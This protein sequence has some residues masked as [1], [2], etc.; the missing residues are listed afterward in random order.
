MAL[1]CLRQQVSEKQLDQDVL[2]VYISHKGA[3][4]N[5]DEQMEESKYDNVT[6][7]STGPCHSFRYVTA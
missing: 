6:G 5:T 3:V 4:S 2:T 7:Q 1:W